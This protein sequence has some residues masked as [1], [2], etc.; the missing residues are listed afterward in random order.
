M[1]GCPRCAGR[2]VGTLLSVAS[3]FAPSAV[4][5]RDPDVTDDCS[6]IAQLMSNDDFPAL[7][8]M[9]ARLRTGELN[10]A[11]ES[12]LGRFYLCMSR[13][14]HGAAGGGGL[15]PLVGLGGALGS[16]CAKVAGSPPDDCTDSAQPG[17]ELPRKWL[18]QHRQC[19]RLGSV[20]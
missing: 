10:A 20:P 11:G 1:Q 2:F 5:A 6:E 19:R 3:L 4:A 7:D 15:E 13:N 14:R 17:L 9:A 8:A 12:R 16:A 18:R